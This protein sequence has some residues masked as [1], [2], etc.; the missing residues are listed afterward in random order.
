MLATLL[1]L[2]LIA[3]PAHPRVVFDAHTHVSS[4]EMDRYTEILDEVGVAWTLNLSGMWPGGPLEH[5]LA[6]ADRSGRMLVA[7]TLPWRIAFTRQDFPQIAAKMIAHAGKIGAR[8]LKI[9]KALGLV[10]QR[11][12]G[13]RLAVDDPWLDPMWIEA[14]KSGLPVVIHTG[15]PKAFWLPVDANNERLEELTAHPKWSNYGEPVPSFEALLLELEHVV[16][17]HPKTT[18]V[19]VHFG[20][21]AED[22]AYVKRMLDTYP[23]YNVDLAARVPEI[24]RHDPDQVRALFIAH[25]RRILFATDLG[26]SPDDFLMLGSFGEEPNKREEVKPFFDAHWRWLETRDD[27]PS[28][29]P[30]QG[31]WTIHGI[32]LPADVLEDIYAKNALRLFGVPTSHPP[33]WRLPPSR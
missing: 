31:R 20:N 12:D 19:S 27:Q 23:N 14:G 1:T 28:M 33:Y 11:P 9:E 32:G 7:M 3:E 29:T 30:I 15:D 6:A 17:R 24:G 5:H 8:A 10:V 13:T 25:R 4:T 26:V 18:F 16:A 2:A 22:L 21:C